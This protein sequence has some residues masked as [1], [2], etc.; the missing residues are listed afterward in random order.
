M[1]VFNESFVNKSIVLLFIF[2]T[3]NSF[4]QISCSNYVLCPDLTSACANG[5]VC[6][7]KGTGYRCCPDNL[8]CCRDG[9]YCCSQ[10][11]HGKKIDMF[12]LD[13][14]IGNEA[15]S[16]ESA[17]I[18]PELSFLEEEKIES[19][20]KN[21][22]CKQY[23]QE[24]FITPINDFLTMH[25]NTRSLNLLSILKSNF[26]FSEAVTNLKDY[27]TEDIIKVFNSVSNKLNELINFKKLIFEADHQDYRQELTKL[28]SSLNDLFSDLKK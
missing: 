24:T 16:S 26:A 14:F 8:V 9:T 5:Q 1:R 25:R 28:L 15:T 11:L 12:S 2:C 21:F 20:E 18:R 6:C 19:S 4:N 13:L 10:D 3:L 23:L 27:C 7:K 22:T 17:V